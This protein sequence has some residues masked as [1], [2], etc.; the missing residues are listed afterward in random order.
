MSTY[1]WERLVPKEGEKIQ[2]Q[3]GRLRRGVQKAFRCVRH[4]INRAVCVQ[5]HRYQIYPKKVN[6]LI[7]K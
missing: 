6:K 1:Q 7:I 2:A 5:A 3:S 4:S